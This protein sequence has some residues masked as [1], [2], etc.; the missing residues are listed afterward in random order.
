M[1]DKEIALLEAQIRELEGQLMDVYFERN[2][3]ESKNMQLVGNFKA[4][5]RQGLIDDDLDIEGNVI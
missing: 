2:A 3:A 4:L 5:K 1:M